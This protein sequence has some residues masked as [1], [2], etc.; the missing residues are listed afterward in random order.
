[1]AL[2]R[3]IGF[4]VSD[5]GPTEH[6]RRHFHRSVGSYTA[7]VEYATSCGTLGAVQSLELCRRARWLVE[8]G[9]IGAI[10]GSWLGVKH[11]S[12]G[13]LRYILSALLLVCGVWMLLS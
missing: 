9:A 10:L 4:P 13:S 2:F 8:Y 1:M 5:D 11:L 6:R 12:S 7:L 3:N